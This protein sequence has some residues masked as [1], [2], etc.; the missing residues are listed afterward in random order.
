VP[1]TPVIEELA[2][3]APTLR[4]RVLSLPVALAVLPVALV[5]AFGGARTQ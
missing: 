4:V 2:L 5:P 1:V 3:V